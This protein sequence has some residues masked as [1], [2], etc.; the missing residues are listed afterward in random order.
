MRLKLTNATLPS[1]GRLF[2]ASRPV[3]VVRADNR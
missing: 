1:L 2:A 3:T